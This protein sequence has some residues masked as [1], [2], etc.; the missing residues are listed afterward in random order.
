[1]YVSAYRRIF[2]MDIHIFEPAP[3]GMKES[4]Y[5]PLNVM[6]EYSIGE[7]IV[8]IDELIARAKSLNMKA[9]AL[10]DRSL[11][12]EMEFYQKC[13]ANDIKPIIGQKVYFS[14]AGLILLCKDFEAYKI[15]CRHSLELISQIELNFELPFSEDECKHFICITE[16]YMDPYLRKVFGADLYAEKVFYKLNFDEGFCERSLA[17]YK[18][19]PAVITNEVRV[20]NESDLEVFKAFV[21]AKYGFADEEQPPFYFV[22]DSDVLLFVDKINRSDLIEN[23]QKIVDQIPYIFPEEYFDAYDSYKRM[24]ENLPEFNE[25]EDQLKK[26]V[27]E[28]I[29][30]LNLERTP[31]LNSRIEFELTDIINKKW[32]NLFLLQREITSWCRENNI[33]YGPGRGAS[34]GSLVAYLLQITDINPLEYGLLYERFVNPDRIT[35]P[36]FDIDYDYEHIED[37]VRHLKE[38]YGENNIARLATYGRLNARNALILAGKALAFPEEEILCIANLIPEYRQITIE[39]LLQGNCFLYKDENP[40]ERPY[41]YISWWDGVK[42]KGFLRD[43]KY[44]ELIRIAKKLEGLIVSHGL[45]ASGY[46]ITKKPVYNYGP[47]QIDSKTRALYCEFPFDEIDCCGLYKNDILGFKELS[48]LEKIK[49]ITGFDYRNIPL[50]DAKTIRSFAKGNTDEIFQFESPG[51]KKILCKFMPEKF[52]DLVVLNAMYRP[53]IMDYIP[54]YLDSKLDPE[55]IHYPDPCLEEIL[56]ETCGII[57]YQEQLMQ[58][59]KKVAGYSLGEADMIRRVMGRKRPEVLIQK[60]KKFVEKALAQGFTEQN[61]EQIFEILIPFASYGFNK[62]HAV[63]YTKMAFWDLYMKVHFKDEYKQV[64]KDIQNYLSQEEVL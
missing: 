21:K 11:A 24:M 53:G 46:I 9:L 27:E 49:N 42:I 8:K 51:M 17:D 30:G 41:W 33:A 60:K 43:K 25:G 28:G 45:H 3:V 5:I 57:V 56:K 7:S 15:L 10:T 62:S 32:T 4:S 38:K 18:E 61:A 36:D 44:E 26:L 64:A 14:S 59:I 52:E 22:D 20:L 16:E 13:K 47:V 2:F 37:V 1:M 55:T 40:D 39:K 6:S 12:G 63:A 19:I 50:D 29:R 23:I 58:V 31:E 54:N 48:K 35:Y 34:G